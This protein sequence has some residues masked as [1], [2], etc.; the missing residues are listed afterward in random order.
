MGFE[1][2]DVARFPAVLN[3]YHRVSEARLECGGELREKLVRLRRC[4]E[5]RHT[6]PI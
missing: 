2:V 5:P 1:I 4:G 3:L 6:S